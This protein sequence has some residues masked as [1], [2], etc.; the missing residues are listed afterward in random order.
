MKTIRDFE[1]KL[2][3]RREIQVVLDAPSNPG[4]KIAEKI[5]EHFKASPELVVIKKVG[6]GF[7]K[8]EFTIEFFIYKNAEA[9]LI[10]PKPKVKKAVGEAAPA[11]AK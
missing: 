2:L 3:N 9:K 11:G 8:S 1:N 7:G 6:T 4:Y 5:A 10:E